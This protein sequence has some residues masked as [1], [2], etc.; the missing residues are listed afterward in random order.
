MTYYMCD[1]CGEDTWNQGISLPG[2]D[3]GTKTR[4]V[5]CYNKKMYPEMPKAL[6][7]PFKPLIGRD[8]S[9]Y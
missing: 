8:G 2:D 5:P 4:C 6:T 3:S 1:I 9:H 7:G